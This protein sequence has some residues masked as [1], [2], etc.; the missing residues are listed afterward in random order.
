MTKLS[1]LEGATMHALDGDVGGVID[2]YFDDQQWVV[3]YAIVKTGLWLTERRVVVSVMSILS[4][5]WDEKRLPVQL[6]RDQIRNGPDVLSHPQIS[7]AIEAELLSYYGYPFYWAGDALW[8]RAANPALA[9]EHSAS[10]LSVPAEQDAD[11]THL[12]SC[13]D[14]IG[15]HIHARDGEIGHVDDLLIDTTAWAVDAIQIDTSNWIGGRSVRLAPSSIGR[16]DWA[17]RSIRVD[18]S[19]ETIASLPEARNDRHETIVNRK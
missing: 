19:R 6:T 13:S 18:L 1:R 3:R 8:G 4:P 11:E 9:A 2:F 17:N 16:I 12:R 10:P 14:L 15:Y 5:D 7:R